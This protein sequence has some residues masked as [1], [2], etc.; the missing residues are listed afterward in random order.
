M[1]R[2]P[3]I[4]GGWALITILN[5]VFLPKKYAPRIQVEMLTRTPMPLI[6]RASGTLEAK[7]SNTVKAQLDGAI[8]L[9]NFREGQQV[10]KDQLLVELSRDKIQLDYQSK[11]DA[12]VNAEQD[13]VHAQR[14]LHLQKQLFK[15]EAVA[16]STVEEAQRTL[17]KAKQDLRGAKEAFKLA[18]NQWNSSSVVAPIAGVIVKDWIAEDKFVADGK[19]IVTVAD[20]SEYT[21][22][23]KVDELDVH[24]VE[25]G[26]KAKILIQI[27]PNQPLAAVVTQVGSPLEGGG[28]P[29]IPIVLRI[30]STEGLDLRP[31]LTAECRIFTGVTEPIL[32]VPLTALMNNDGNPYVWG[33]NK[34]HRLQKRRVQLGRA[35]PER[36]EILKGLSLGDR[37]C[38][39]AEP[40]YVDGM[41]A[42]TGDPAAA[43]GALDRTAK[44][45]P[46]T[47]K[48]SADKRKSAIRNLSL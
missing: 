8:V 38:V 10:K 24:Q 31:K 30:L 45:L 6:V 9:K 39:T 23:A 40:D 2:W 21:V 1:K 20:V 4:V 28:L 19:E 42:I 32:S 35:N 29:E 7:D 17:V 41:Q 48:D 22:H 44:F 3:F 12:L 11:K 36:I 26:Q 27:F 13:L 37:V 46:E 33:L 47:K 16:Y 5:V 25:E 34:L 18:Q 43:E 15:K 14:D